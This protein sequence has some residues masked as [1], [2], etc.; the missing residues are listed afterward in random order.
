ML[1]ISN[2][3]KNIAAYKA[4]VTGIDNIRMILEFIGIL[5]IQNKAD[6]PYAPPIIFQKWNLYALRMIGLKYRAPTT[7]N[8]IVKKIAR[9]NKN[10][11]DF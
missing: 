5:T 7:K 2:I 8:I 1:S 4:D 10:K 11:V 6:T 9:L 3:E